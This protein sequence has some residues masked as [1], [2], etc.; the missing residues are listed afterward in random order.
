MATDGPFIG[1]L[2]VER[3]DGGAR[4][5]PPSDH[6]DV[7]ARTRSWTRTR[8]LRGQRSHARGRIARATLELRNNF[9][10]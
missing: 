6:M 2:I 3:Q 1:S 7:V 4:P 5:P 8:L 10:T 9:S